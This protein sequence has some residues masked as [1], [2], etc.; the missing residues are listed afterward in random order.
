MFRF[1][2]PCVLACALRGHAASSNVP[3]RMGF[4]WPSH[5]ASL[6]RRLVSVQVL[7]LSFLLLACLTV[8]GLA[9][10]ATPAASILSFNAAQIGVSGGSVQTLTASFA[11]SGYAGSFTPTATLHYGHDYSLGAV[12]C[13]G[14]ASE[15]CT[16]PVTFQPTLPGT[17]KDA[18]FLMNGSTRLATVLLNGAG[19]GPMSLLQPGAFTTSVPSS[20]VNTSGY[21]YIYQSVADENGTVYLLPSGSAHFILSVSKAGAVTEI[22]LTNPPYFWTIGIDG[23][24]VLYLFDES[25][26]VS[27]YD[28][29]QGIQ[30]TY[31]LPYAGADTNWFPGTVD[32]FGNFYI[33]DQILNN[34]KI[35]EF[36]ADRTSNFASVLN[37]AV[38]QPNAIAV[39]SQGNAFVGGYQ[40]D[41]ISPAG[42]T[43][44]VNTVGASDGLA[45]DAADTLYATRYSLTGGVAELPASNYSTAIASIDTSSSPLG[46]SLGSDGTVFVSNYV[47]L[48]VFDR[49]TAETIDFGQVNTGSSQAGSASSIYNGGNESLT[50]SQFSL[51]GAGFSVDSSQPSD[52]FSGIVL[53]PGSLCEVSVTFSP[54]HPGTYTGTIA[55]ESNS[56]NGSN[57]AQT[58]QL[59]GISYGSYDVVTPNPL[60][61]PGQATGTSQ[62]L[63]V[64]LT[65]QGNIYPSTVYSVSTDNAA[66]TIAEGTCT[67]V[68]VA[69]GSSCQLQVTFTP[70][71]AQ[72][73]SGNATINTFVNGT[74]QAHQIITLPL[75]GT[76]NGPIA[77]TPAIT[78]GTGTYSSS[79][80]VGITDA[81]A[82]ATIYY[83]TDGSVPSSASTKYTGTIT[84]NSNETLKAIATAPSYSQS[85]VASATY[86]FA[87]PVA[88]FTPSSV[89]FPNQAVGTAS[90]TQTITLS[91]TGS[92]ALTISSIAITGANISDFAQT[93]NCPASVAAG[94]SCNI[95]VTFTPA[96]AASFSAAVTVT[97]NASGSPQQ[98]A[99]TGTG[100]IQAPAFTI[101]PASIAFGNQIVNSTSANKTVAFTNTT[102][103][104]LKVQTI[105][106]SDPAF[107][108]NLPV[109]GCQ[110][111]IIPGANPGCDLFVTFSPKAVQ[112]YGATLTVQVY[113]ITNPATSFPSQ[114]FT[115]AGTGIA[116]PPAFTIAPTAVAFG[117][118]IVNT[119]SAN[120]TVAFTNATNDILKVQ[121][122]SSSDPAFVTNLPASGCQMAII[123]SANPGC[124]LY[125]TFSP[126]AIQAYSAT[127]TIQVYDITNPAVS[128]PTQTFTVRGTGIAAPPAFTINPASIAF[129]NQLINTTSA[130]N[131]VAFTNTTNDIVKVQSIASSDPAFA[132][133]LPASGCQMAIIPS[134]NPG[135]DLYVT[136]SPTA[137]Q[138]YSATLTI[139]VYDI[140]N[141]AVSFPAQ[142]FTVTGTGIAAPPAFTINPASI[143][144]GNQLINTTSANNTVA[145]TNTTNDFVKVQS[146]SSS[147]PA[148][149]TNLPVSG[150]QTAII[151]GANPGCDLYVTFSP[152]AMQPYNATLT[153][154]VHDITN[155]AVSFPAQTFTVTGTGVGPVS[156][157]STNSLSFSATFGT[158]SAAQPVTLSNNGTGPLLISNISFGGGSPNDY[159]QTNNCP[160]LLDVGMNCIISVTFSSPFAGSY[161]ASLMVSDNDPT[162]PQVVNLTGDATNTPNF[163]V[164]SPSQPQD[165]SPGGSAQF[166]IIVTAENGASIPAVTLAATGLP[167]G[168]TASFAQ[169]SIT[170]G[171]ASATTTLT[172]HMPSTSASNHGSQVPLEGAATA[173]PALAL[174]GWLFVPRRQRQR[175]IILG[176][177][178]LASLGG[179]SAL[180]GCAGG[181]LN[182]TPPAKT[183]AVTVTASIGTVQQT[184]TVKLTVE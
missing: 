84:V 16:V 56:L 11:V 118:Q 82:G 123:P 85:A 86:T 42:G 155:P 113:D 141:P 143:A 32:G 142:T 8:P 125:V 167:P 144:F 146:I 30:G 106:S 152:T 27:T 14:G 6:A 80:Q 161:P 35:Y 38:V 87:Y 148:F 37:P 132:T 175:W 75:S 105:T 136:F 180:A 77:A 165:I 1:P 26:T 169:A 48:D 127:L 149:A 5:S 107:A 140:S 90:G 61:F 122:I 181:G 111:A 18:I 99:L 176:L 25:K 41:E 100:F 133:N 74:A 52:C 66:F 159:I 158:T 83:T 137:M 53:A 7:L 51:S 172:I 145:F 163:V 45:V 69:V 65:N 112:S 109:S 156:S 182:M 130:H 3:C 24:G 150:C 28:T 44:Q 173:L 154:Q 121:S 70:A 60:V 177:L 21:D 115:V 76:G 19:Q 96:S 39:D 134:A 129:G 43:S 164:A 162:M 124:D 101:V 40:I 174:L 108:T 184:T 34:G 73:Y 12:S 9:Q 49:S 89:A 46:V 95:L 126:T 128:F 179:V 29:V 110:M 71:A 67:S 138:A 22:P 54:G 116:A 151:P 166:S 78:P 102:S 31:V 135:C 139:Q 119:T 168:A 20:S 57:V 55:I 94:S 36:N 103:D 81:T 88:T 97:D 170:P 72:S 68:T 15:T 13:S 58:I 178:L 117:D 63:P 147:D 33:V 92:A 79:Q 62:T 104:I 10:T 50:L 93:N 23:A 64:T 114:T 2:D 4:S 157:L 91:N 17:R 160:L 59:T 47:N 131:T 98:A 183:Y 171:A 120:K 153:V